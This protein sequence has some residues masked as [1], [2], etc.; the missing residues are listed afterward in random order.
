MDQ[1]LTRPTNPFVGPRAIQENE[2]LFGREKE[3]EDLVDQLY[4]ERVVLMYSPS[5]AGKS[6]LIN[7]GLIPQVKS[8]F[9]VL[10]ILRLNRDLPGN[11]A[12]VAGMDRYTA[13]VLSCLYAP[14]D[15]PDGELA[16]YPFGESP[17]LLI[18]DQ[19][20]EVITL[21]QT[22]IDQKKTFFEKLGKLLKRPSMW[23]LFAMREDYLAALDPYRLSLPGQL[24]SRFRLDLFTAGQAVDV[25][26]KTAATQQVV[27][28]RLAA[29]RL[30][31]ILGGSHDLT[32]P[33]AALLSPGQYIEPVHVQL[34]C[35]DLWEKKLQPG[36]DQITQEMVEEPGGVDE[37]LAR[38]YA[39]SLMKIAIACGV[40]ERSLRD[41]FENE[42]ITRNNIR[43]QV[44][45]GHPALAGLGSAVGALKDAY[46]LRSENRQGTTWYELA[47]D[48]LIN[49]I[50]AD[51]KGWYE[52]NLNLGQVQANL[53][54]QQDFPRELLLRGTLLDD[55]ESWA[56]S[57]PL[58]MT[59]NDQSFI[60]T[61]L[62]E[63]RDELA[64]QELQQQQI[65][66][67]HKLAEAQRQRAEEQAIVS[68]RLRRQA[69]A[70]AILMVI[71]VITAGLAG[72]LWI[73]QM[74]STENAY[75]AEALALDQRN[76]AQAAQ[77]YAYD[78]QVTAEIAGANADELR[79]IAETARAN[80]EEQQSI[81]A[82]AGANAQVQYENAKAAEATA[83]MANQVAEAAQKLLHATAQAA[84]VQLD[85]APE[86]QATAQA[87]VA[88][89]TMQATARAETALYQSRGSCDKVKPPCTYTI[90]AG[91]SFS[92]LVSKFYNSPEAISGLLEFN[93]DK[94]GY[95]RRLL[96]GDQIY[97]PTQQA[98]LRKDI[99]RLLYPECWKNE[100]P[101]WYL[102]EG[103]ETY[104]T[105]ALR[106][107]G[108]SAYS[109]LIIDSN[110]LWNL[111]Y[112]Q[113]QTGPVI[114]QGGYLVLPV[115]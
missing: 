23:A 7:A 114:Y 70:L 81:A 19:F 62:E 47:H 61:C 8:S 84:G 55:F 93:R 16:S 113:L 110:W 89:D 74:D 6:S 92:Y 29:E 48:R 39:S 76:T 64:K 80:A 105:I 54:A 35:Y 21:E 27:F 90:Q 26:I 85:P 32:R 68:A 97:I 112:E 15:P 51:N 43:T 49:P 77:A 83:V 14:D 65:D 52:Q 38:F 4:A 40:S 24:R 10:P 20:E 22:D 72:Y 60:E 53:W 69:L 18:F 104:E 56:G 66:T 28:Q 57:H 30:A 46:L 107:Y 17:A 103:N 95:R 42:L 59:P 2:P 45:T 94:A 31:S 37:A 75:F 12:M 102:T 11:L 5:G 36:D 91:D 41:L 82:T 99:P 87:Q 67:A 1:P 100:F 101:C 63:R 79:I 58:M 88:A 106:F 86:L 98:V 108:D 9:R 33:D 111:K 96:P 71:A 73:Q 34:V 115:P 13:S 25:V 109:K 3:L 44:Q 50:R 78:Q